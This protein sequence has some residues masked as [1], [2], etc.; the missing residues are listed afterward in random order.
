M[1]MSQKITANSSRDYVYQLLRNDILRLQLK[2]G[3][4]ISEKEVSSRFQVSRTPV[5]EAFLQ[6]SQEGLLEVYPQRGTFVSLI[7]L[8]LVEEGRFMR[9]QL[10]KAVIRLACDSFPQELL[11]ALEM[12]LKMQEMCMEENDYE[13]LFQLDEEFHRMIFEGCDKIRIWLAIQQMNTDFNRI[14]ML[15]LATNLNWENILLHHSRLVHAIK[16]KDAELA[17]QTMHDH[18]TMVVFDKEELKQKYPNY[19]K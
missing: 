18:L 17:E 13:R 16:N 11:F 14:R 2:P 7:D 5:R 10:E 6:L 1:K 3:S 8:T 9:E 19:F 15:R 12:N 4:S